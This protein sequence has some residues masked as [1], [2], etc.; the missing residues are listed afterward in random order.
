MCGRLTYPLRI[1]VRPL[2]ND[3]DP[4]CIGRKR[5]PCPKP[6]VAAGP[7]PGVGLLYTRDYKADE[8]DNDRVDVSGTDFRVDLY[9]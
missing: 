7:L 9:F 8:Y 2:H 3:Y 1:I 4:V 5:F 6:A